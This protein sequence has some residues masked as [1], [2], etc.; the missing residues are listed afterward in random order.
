[1][2]HT[3]KLLKPAVVSKA[4]IVRVETTDSDGDRIHKRLLCVMRRDTGLRSRTSMVAYIDGVPKPE[5]V[6]G[7]R[8][9][10]H[11]EFGQRGIDAA[12]DK[13]WRQYNRDEVAI[14]RQYVGAAVAGLRLPIAE[15][16][17]SQKAGCSCGCSSGFRLKFD[18]SEERVQE[19]R[20]LDLMGHDLFIDVI[21]L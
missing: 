13:A 4:K 15:I 19:I 20:P 17:F 10:E 8:F 6:D 3:V 18:T 1:M 5:D 16:N 11:P 7:A 2:K 12:V 14:M 9:T 21:D